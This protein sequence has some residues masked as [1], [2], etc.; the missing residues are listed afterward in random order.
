MTS[1]IL[2]L[3]ASGMLGSGFAQTLPADQLVTIDRAA[4]ADP[5]GLMH[6]LAA[7]SPRVIINCAADTNVESAERNPAPAFATNAL[8][9]SLLAQVARDQGALLIHFSSTGCYGG[10]AT[11]PHSDYAPLAPP[12]VHHRSKAA[13]EQAIR[14]A[15]CRHLILRLG[16]LYGGTIEHRKNFAWA[17][18]LEA[19]GKPELASDPYQTGSPTHIADVVAQ[20][21]ALLESGLTGTYN[22]VATGDV[23][24]YDYVARILACAAL[25]PRLIP[26]R[27][28]RA[29][30]V[31]SNE[32]A[33]NDKLNQLGL[34]H[35]P[36]WDDALTRYVQSLLAAEATTAP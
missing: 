8:L 24:R 11:A 34:N 16:W 1:P 17:R 12:T 32:A 35:M 18:I 7:K 36:D 20:T 6:H 21:M 23:T 10:T 30:P 5:L 26:K 3:G 33:V 13:G 25:T 31:A 28:I 19:R 15:G 4:T 9:P 27:F 22:C 14:D 2:L 29:A